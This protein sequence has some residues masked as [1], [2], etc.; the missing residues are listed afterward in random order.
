MK[1]GGGWIFLVLALVAS[2]DEPRVPP[3]PI[4]AFRGARLAGKSADAVAAEFVAGGGTY[5]FS[6]GRLWEIS[7]SEGRLGGLR[8]VR[9]IPSRCRALSSRARGTPAASR[10]GWRAERLLRTMGSSGWALFSIACGASTDARLA[11]ETAQAWWGHRVWAADAS[12]QWIDEAFAE[13]AAA[14]AM[15]VLKGA[16][17]ARRIEAAWRKESAGAVPMAPLSL[18][19]DLTAGL[20]SP[21]AFTIYRTRAQLLSFKGALLLSALRR[22]IGEEKLFAV[23][24]SFLGARRTQPAITTD[25][26]VGFLSAATKKD[27][28]PWFERYFYGFEMP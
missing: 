8:E 12:N 10:S 13:L 2:A 24:K 14:R 25:D 26:F 3:D 28:K 23:L 22:E 5:R 4:A 16:E 17:E 27:W 21:Q 15:G 20:T 6:S 1:P 19:K 11:H 18:A 9:G 7:S